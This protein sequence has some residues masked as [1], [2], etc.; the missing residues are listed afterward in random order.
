MY[1]LDLLLLG[2]CHV[3]FQFTGVQYETLLHHN[4]TFHPF[5]HAL[6]GMWNVE[7]SND[8]IVTI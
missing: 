7:S 1:L 6:Q 3:A 5:Y 8:L 4:I 2:H